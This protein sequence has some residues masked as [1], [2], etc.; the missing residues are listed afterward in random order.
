MI[1]RELS[2]QGKQTPL[3]KE[4]AATHWGQIVWE[5]GVAISGSD[6]TPQAMGSLAR[7]TLKADSTLFTL[8]KNLA[9]GK[10]S[11]KSNKQGY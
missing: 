7:V 3:C 10:G 9:P 1:E 8:F 2:G 5:R 4:D 6:F 11:G